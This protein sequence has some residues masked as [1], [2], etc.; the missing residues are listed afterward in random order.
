MGDNCS[1]PL[2][3]SVYK[4]SVSGNCH[5]KKS[6]GLRNSL[7]FGITVRAN[8]CFWKA[9]RIQAHVTIMKSFIIQGRR[10]VHIIRDVQFMPVSES[11]RLISTHHPRCVNHT[12]ICILQTDPRWMSASWDCCEMRQWEQGTDRPLRISLCADSSMQTVCLRCKHD[13][14]QERAHLS[15]TY[16]DLHLSAYTLKSNLMFTAC[17]TGFAHPRAWMR[18]NALPF[19]HILTEPDLL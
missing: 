8:V 5:R 17:Q 15:C 18:I 12:S 16:T 13:S 7:K 4:I 19:L 1:I 3:T 14:T 11:W 9:S 10:S 6:S 2:H